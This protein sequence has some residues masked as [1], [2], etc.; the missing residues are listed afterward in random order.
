MKYRNLGQ[1]GLRVSTVS[2]GSWMT[3]GRMQQASVNELVATAIDGGINFLDTADIYDKGLAES[4]LGQAVKGR[5]RDHLVLASKA[6]WPMSD[7]PNDRGLSRKHL[8]ESC[9]ASLKRLG[10]DYLDLYQCHRFDPETPL[11]E[12]VRAMGDL[13]RQ[14]K[15]LY[16]G[17]SVWDAQQLREACRIADALQVPRPASEQPRYN[18]LQREIETDVVPACAELG[19]G[20]I[21]W[22]PLAQGIL[23]GKY[24]GGVNPESRAADQEGIGRFMAE[25]VRN[26]EWKN[27]VRDLQNIASNFGMPLSQ[28]ALAWCLRQE[29]LSSVI[30]G[31]TRIEQLSE[32]LQAADLDWTDECQQAIAQILDRQAVA[33]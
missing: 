1:T 32:N 21:V 7:S 25:D 30:V 11:E 16:W 3:F 31:A 19:I 15:I 24:L 26:E 23:T 4:L 12:T 20:L 17:T 6:F 13:I 8:F 14:G 29:A 2:F 22:S 18:M 10:T 28:M 9:H 27:L 33:H 5:R